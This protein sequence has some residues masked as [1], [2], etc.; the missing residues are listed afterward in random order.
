VVALRGNRWVP[1]LVLSCLAAL[2]KEYGLLLGLVCTAIA[3]RRDLRKIAVLGT[4]LPTML[5]LV[6]I[7]MRS[8]FS[9]RSLDVWQGFIS[10]MFDYHRYLLQ[11][12]GV[13]GF[14]QLQYMWSWSVLWP[15]MMVAG[16]T[17]LSRLRS[18]RKMSDDEI[19]FLLTLPALPVLL[20]G[21]WGRALLIVV[22]FACAVATSNPLARSTPFTGLLAL[23]GV[24]TALARPFH[25]NSPPPQIFMYSMIAISVAA[26]LSIGLILVR[27]VFFKRP[28]LS[29]S[30]MYES[31]VEVAVP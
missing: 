11:L 21:D 12:R 22:P 15:L 14:L 7:L 16:A 24:S 1:A 13:F 18:G 8:D 30:G 5:L 10:A 29:D 19:A 3:W 31:M 27:H 17:I 20:L 6:A 28:E 9:R 4:I 26:S 23:G 25:S 2:T